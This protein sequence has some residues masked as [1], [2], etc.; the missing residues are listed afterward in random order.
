M[1][2][3][4]NGYSIW[5]SMEFKLVTQSVF[6]IICLFPCLGSFESLQIVR[7]FLAILLLSLITFYFLRTSHSSLG[8]SLSPMTACWKQLISLL[9]VKE[10]PIFSG[11]AKRSLLNLERDLE[12]GY[13]FVC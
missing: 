10:M 13:L 7:R 1:L 9:D 3:T 12:H 11:D 4:V 8:A 2:L 6:D 5:V